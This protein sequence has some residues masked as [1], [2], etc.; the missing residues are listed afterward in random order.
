MKA[1]VLLCMLALV[2][3]SSAAFAQPLPDSLPADNKSASGPGAKIPVTMPGDPEVLGAERAA[4]TAP[5]APVS[6][7]QPI[8][9]TKY[10]CGPGDSFELN[11]WGQQNFRL[12]IS[13]DLEGRTFISK[14][15]F[16]TVAGKTL[17]AVRKAIK[18]KVRANYPGLQFELTLS[19][20]RTFLVHVVD[21]V[22]KP[23]IYP[24]NPVER[25]SSLL[26][27]AGGITGSKRRIAIRH[28]DGTALTADL[29]Q[30]E[31][32]GNTELNPYLVDG[33]VV[34]VPFAETTVA[35]TGAVHRPGNYELIK[36]KDLAELLE[37]AGGLTSGVARGLPIRVVRRNGKQQEVFQDLAFSGTVA[38]NAPLHDLDQVVVPGAAELQRSVLLIGAVVGAESVDAAATSKRLPFVE[39][40]TVWSLIERAGGIKAPGDLKRSYIARPQPN[41]TPNVIPVDLDALLVRRDF[42]ADVAIAMGDAIVIPPM[43]YSILVE[44]SVAHAG[45]YPY[46]PQFGVREYVAHAGGL[47][48]N[49]Q[50]MDDVRIIDSAGATR[51]YKDKTPLH[52]GD[53][54]LVPERNWTRAEIVQVVMGG[55]GLLLSGLALGYAITR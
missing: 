6:V 47:T 51:H 34:S 23:G 40:D 15:G 26:A 48:H 16:V 31:L 8:D 2:A 42:H 53:A 20:P 50:D 22:S 7:E 41:G 5:A 9:P 46:N 54:I 44:G 43:Q 30:Y 17:E 14:V 37:L 4:T 12:K 1:R 10:I 55:A 21:N 35:I 25:V 27:R 33:D 13:V 49:A 18:E 45:V 32:T 11:F 28:H 3:I 38:P 29:V 36:A 39:G 24:T 52:P 19:T